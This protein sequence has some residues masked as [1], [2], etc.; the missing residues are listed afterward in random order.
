VTFELADLAALPGDRMPTDSATSPPRADIVTANLT[1][2]LLCRAAPA[3]AGLLAPGGRLVVSGLLATEQAEV[4]AAFA[5]LRV[6]WDD[7]EDEWV[8]LVLTDQAGGKK[9]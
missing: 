7:R 1:G 2:A 5:S 8:C 4:E 6:I 9:R 3:L